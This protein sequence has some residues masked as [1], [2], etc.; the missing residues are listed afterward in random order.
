[1]YAHSHF[2]LGGQRT[3][4]L[5]KLTFEQE[6]IWCGSE[7]ENKGKKECVKFERNEGV[8]GDEYMEDYTAVIDDWPC[9]GSR[10]S[11]QWR[12]RNRESAVF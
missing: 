8:Q 12:D 2:S 7:K 9:G 3:K 5:L 11:H 1:M 10:E 6:F 4:S